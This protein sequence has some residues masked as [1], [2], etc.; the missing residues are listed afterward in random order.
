MSP[1]DARPRIAGSL[2][3]ARPATPRPAK[4]RLAELTELKES[5]LVTSEEF[6]RARKAILEDA[7]A[8]LAPQTAPPAAMPQPST[9]ADAS[10]SPPQARGHSTST[11]AELSL[12]D[13]TLK[14]QF[15]LALEPSTGIKETLRQANEYFGLS[16]EGT[17][18]QQAD[19]LLAEMGL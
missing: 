4:Q 2:R 5:G 7:F 17:P 14:I 16:E 12:K 19:A 9:R 18:S 6:E 3:P 10:G 11:A 13:K 1:L 8:P 15:E